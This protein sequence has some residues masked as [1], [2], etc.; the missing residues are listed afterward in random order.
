MNKKP[1]HYRLNNWQIFIVK[2]V[3]STM[4]EIKKEQYKNSLNT[5]LMAYKQSAGR[6]RNKNKWISNLGNI[7]LSIKLNSFFSTNLFILNYL[8]GIIIFDT[9]NFF[10]RK[11]NNFFIK[12]PNDILVDNKKIA[13]ILID[14]IS[15]GGKVSEYYIGVGL[16]TKIAPSNKNYNTTCLKNEGVLKISRKEILSKLI[17][18]FN[19]WETSFKKNSFSFIIEEWM[20]RS[21][22]INSPI[23]FRENN[24]IINGVYKGIDLDGAI[25]VSINSKVNK[26]FSLDTSY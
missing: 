19:Y 3:D 14:T 5:I 23:A 13:G 20:K 8:T 11:K 4:D 21:F 2:K 7:F 26:F 25:K 10:L 9:L 16:N 6:G 22:P 12:W 1:Y 15:N 24:H 18:Y 17:Y